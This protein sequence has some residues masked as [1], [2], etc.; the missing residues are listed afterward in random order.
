MDVTRAE[1]ITKL[2]NAYE[3]AVGE[4]SSH[5]NKVKFAD[6]ARSKFDVT[7]VPQTLRK[8]IREGCTRI[9]ATG[10]KPSMDESVFKNISAALN[11]YIAISQVN[12]DPKNIEAALFQHWNCC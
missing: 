12:G 8:L 2:Q 1:G 3:W 9:L 11:S 5:K 7:V 10:P 6:I 4:A